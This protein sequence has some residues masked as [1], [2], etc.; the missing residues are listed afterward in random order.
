MGGGGG[1]T[2]VSTD[3]ELPPP[4]AE[5]ISTA[6]A[7]ITIEIDRIKTDFLSRGRMVLGCSV[8]LR[9]F[10]THLGTMPDSATCRPVDKRRNPARSR[11]TRT[12]RERKNPSANRPACDDRFI[13][14]IAI[15]S[16]RWIFVYTVFPYRFHQE[17]PSIQTLLCND[18]ADV[19]EYNL[20]HRRLWGPFRSTVGK[21]RKSSVNRHAI[22]TRYQR[23]LVA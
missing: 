7:V 6:Q 5:R 23:R 11:G 13:D 20:R 19:V 3:D 17:N 10:K 22:L 9:S 12:F 16:Q 8:L 15:F 4:Q 21:H 18:D 14:R 1:E 2:G